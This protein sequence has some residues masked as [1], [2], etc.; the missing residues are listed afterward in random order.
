MSTSGTYVW[1]LQ[2]DAIINSALRKLAVLAGG[3]TPQTYEITNAAEA[4]NAMIKGLMVEGMPVWNTLEYSFPTAANT[5]TYN[6]GIGQT[7][8]TA[9][10][11]KVFQADRVTGTGAPNVPMEIKTHYDFN[12]LPVNVSSGVPVHL[13]YQPLE[14]YG[15]I[16]VWPTPPDTTTTIRIV[17]QT[18]FSDMNA[19]TDNV[20]FPSYW[21]EALIYGLA[22]RLSPEYGI[23]LMDRQQFMKDYEYFKQEALSFGTE[24]GSLFI[25]PDWVGRK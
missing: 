1:S 22:W 4:L 25:T 11:M 24:E 23:P 8:N 21:T 14:T 17:Y 13:F 15:V 20:D 3:A 16:K 7:L 18:P 12:L 10:P 6:I 2:R 5:N 9:M 19:S